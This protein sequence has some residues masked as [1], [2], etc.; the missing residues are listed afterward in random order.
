MIVT[1]RPGLNTDSAVCRPRATKSSRY[2]RRREWVGERE[3]LDPIRQAAVVR[4]RRLVPGRRSRRADDVAFDREACLQVSDQ[5]RPLCDI[6]SHDRQAGS[7]G[8]AEIGAR[9]P[10]ASD[11]RRDH[12]APSTRL[13]PEPVKSPSD[14]PNLR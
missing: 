8:G 7:D 2:R 11:S 1:A 10:R 12:C 4:R 9:M 5:I 14:L 6:H 3:R 13:P